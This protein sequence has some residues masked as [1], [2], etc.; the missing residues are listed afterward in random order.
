MRIFYD[1]LTR[2][3][4]IS[5]LARNRSCLA[6][7]MSV[8]FGSCIPYRK[9]RNLLHDAT[10]VRNVSCDTSSKAT[11]VHSVNR[12]NQLHWSNVDRQRGSEVRSSQSCRHWVHRAILNPH[13]SCGKKSE[14]NLF[15][16][17]YHLPTIQADSYNCSKHV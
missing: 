12:M 3:E 2:V 1:Q 8:N 11:A 10:N 14:I 15:C 13:I 17:L 6:D 9:M 16:K 4:P 5:Q 7:T